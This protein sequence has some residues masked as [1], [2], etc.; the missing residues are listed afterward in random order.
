MAADRRAQSR[1][2]KPRPP[3]AKAAA[4]A[5]RTVRLHGT[6][7]P[8]I[9]SRF[10]CAKHRTNLAVAHRRGGRRASA[11]APSR[12]ACRM[13]AAA[14]RTSARTSALIGAISSM[15]RSPRVE[16]WVVSLLGIVCCSSCSRRVRDAHARG[17]KISAACKTARP[18]RRHSVHK[19]NSS[20]RPAARRRH[21]DV[22]KED[23]V[24][25]AATSS[26]TSSRRLAARVFVLTFAVIPTAALVP[27]DLDAACSTFSPRG[28]DRARVFMAGW[29]SHNNTR[30]RAMRALAQLISYELP[31]LSRGCRS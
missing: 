7:A 17:K 3:R 12:S 13:S 27:L 28:R 29:A 24:P 10:A 4:A 16:L 25:R 19:M 11:E 20:S 6:P 23:I 18:N 8:P 9:T 1:E 22:T 31:L 5:R 26:S 15:M 30:C 21:Q 14:S 2:E